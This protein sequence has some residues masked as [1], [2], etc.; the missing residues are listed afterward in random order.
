MA[1]KITVFGGSEPKPG[2]KAYQQARILGQELSRAG[3]I[4][5]TGGYMGTMEATSLGAAEMGGHVI[6]VTC[7]E[8]EKWRPIKHNQWVSEEIRFPTLRQRL[9]AMI[10]ECDAAIALPGGIGT[11][12]EVAM[13]WSQLQVHSITAK[14]LVLVGARWEAVINNFFQQME[15]YILAEHRQWLAFASDVEKVIPLLKAYF[16]GKPQKS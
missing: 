16:A 9:F 8:I 5:M 15:G 3:Y 11:L 2:D 4:V 10:D 6:G 7:D 14:P 1:Y 13:M 12:A